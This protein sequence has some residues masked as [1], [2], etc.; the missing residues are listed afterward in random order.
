V[1]PPP[2]VASEQNIS[3]EIASNEMGA[4][5]PEEESKVLGKNQLM[6]VDKSNEF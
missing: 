6:E 2:S 1:L 5:S 4:Q 3:L